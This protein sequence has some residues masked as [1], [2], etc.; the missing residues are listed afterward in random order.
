MATIKSKDIKV[1]Q[2][3]FKELTSKSIEDQQEFFL[4]SFIFALEEKWKEVPTLATSF[5]K[6]LRDC[7]EG[8]DDLN[9]IQAADFLQKNGLE[10]TAL[11]RK[12][13][14]ADIDLDFNGRIAF[15]EYLMLHFKLMILKEYY[16]RT[17]EAAKEDLSK[18][19]I[20]ITGVGNKLIDELFTMPLSLSPEL[21]RA[22]EDFTAM[23]KERENK[24]KD[25]REKAAVGGVKGKAAENE[26]KQL[27]TQDQTQTNK[28]EVTLEAAKKKA[29]NT[30]EQELKIK[31]QKEE[32]EKKKKLD[33]GRS[34][35]AARA[36]AF[37]N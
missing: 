10:R 30:G 34:K 7:N 13:E 37:G 35:I 12:E 21:V 14:L 22:I 26:I 3:Q 23:K 16:K 33:E 32:E 24:L 27:D 20:G 8:K 28:M 5:R 19:G 36:A 31:L 4:K 29:K 11:Q 25:L 6:Y 2:E 18:N 9:Q 15:I 1:L 17:G